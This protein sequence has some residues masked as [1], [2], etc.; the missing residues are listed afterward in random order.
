MRY[1]P[2]HS[3]A[4]STVAR[5]YLTI[6]TNMVPCGSAC[7]VAGAGGVEDGGANLCGYHA[8]M[9]SAS[10]RFGTIPRRDRQTTETHE[11]RMSIAWRHSD[12]IARA[13]AYRNRDAPNKQATQRSLQGL[14]L[15]LFFLFFLFVYKTRADTI[16]PGDGT[17]GEGKGACVG[18]L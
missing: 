17:G 14:G 18:G 10:S 3:S 5:T 8:S 4:L 12:I 11:P 16:S 1:R 15:F 2:Y 13:C 9:R 7:H 6:A